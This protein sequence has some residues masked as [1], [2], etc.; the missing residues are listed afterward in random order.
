MT[1]DPLSAPIF[2]SE[3]G[4]PQLNSTTSITSSSNTAKTSLIFQT[5]SAIPPLPTAFETLTLI[6]HSEHSKTPELL[7]ITLLITISLIALIYLGGICLAIM[8]WLR[9]RCESCFEKEKKIREL[10]VAL[11]LAKVNTDN[12]L[13][14]PP[15]QTQSNDVNNGVHRVFRTV[16]PI[17][18]APPKYTGPPPP[19]WPGE[20][21]HTMVLDTSPSSSLDP[22]A[23][24]ERIQS[25]WQDK[26]P[27][28][29]GR[30]L[31]YP[32]KP[33]PRRSEPIPIAKR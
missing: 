31:L 22:Q 19:E 26:Q 25:E 2:P 13:P 9:P 21:I 27:W 29:A 20:D 24:L 1:S 12:S 23:E 18:A 4:I 17:L 30:S 5:G 11:H 6:S 10:E 7:I 3:S 16:E 28:H 33:V 14:P 15:H 8:H 32:E